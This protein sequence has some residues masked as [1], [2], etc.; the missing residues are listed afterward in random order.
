M[1][2]NYESRIKDI[3]NN[4]SNLNVEYIEKVFKLNSYKTIRYFYNINRLGNGLWK[5]F[6]LFNH[7]CL[8]NTTNFGIG[9]FI[10]LMPNRVIKKGEEI[11][12]LY[13]TTPKHYEART[14]LYQKMYNFECN[15]H[16]CELEKKIV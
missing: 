2:Q 14:D 10:F 16:L 12:V 1:K 15:C 8:P 9:D 6:S 7:S 3:Q 13:L 4:I 5:F 11:T